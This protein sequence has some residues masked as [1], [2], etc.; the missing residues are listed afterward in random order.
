M[1]LLFDI[2]LTLITTGGCG[3]RAMS[4]AGK[5]LFGESFTSEGVSYAGRLDPLIIGE[6]FARSGVRDTPDHRRALRERY[7]DKLR[8]ALA[9]SDQKRSLPGVA[10]LLDRLHA[11]AGDGFT[12]GLLTGN[13]EE[14]GSLKLAA[15]GVDVSRFAV[16]VWGDH[17]PHDPPSRD[18][19]VPV[20]MGRYEA[21]LRRSI[22]P[23]RVVVIGDTEHDVRCARVNGCRAVGVATGRTSAE[24]LSRAGADLVL[25]DLARQPGIE[26][27]L[28]SVVD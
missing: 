25:P 24:E 4:T 7:A 23:D 3:F 10:D 19:L 22:P 12:L 5:E 1:L 28:A 27:W 17:S 21:L 6:M 8:A 2:D 20:A 13:F 26:A 11:R 16:R 15:C 18:H 14:T 9:E